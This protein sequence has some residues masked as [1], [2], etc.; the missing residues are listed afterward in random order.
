MII[1][2]VLD[3]DAVSTGA[4]SKVLAVLSIGGT[5]AMGSVCV[6]DTALTIGGTATVGKTCVRVPAGTVCMTDICLLIDVLLN[7]ECIKAC[8]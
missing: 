2:V 8:S 1:T 6:L 3:E 7:P 5:V 4:I